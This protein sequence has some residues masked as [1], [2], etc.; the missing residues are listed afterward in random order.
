VVKIAFHA[1]HS[2]YVACVLTSV[3]SSVC[4]KL[5]RKHECLLRRRFLYNTVQQID[6]PTFFLQRQ[7]ITLFMF[8]SC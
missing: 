1:V 2:R 6:M 3:F 7:H 4:V 5:S 8:C